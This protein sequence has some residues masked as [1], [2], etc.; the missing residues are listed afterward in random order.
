MM[1]KIF[2]HSYDIVVDII[3]YRMIGLDIDGDIKP[4]CKQINKG[5]DLI[6]E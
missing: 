4:T 3:A 6:W 2:K 5:I 1:L